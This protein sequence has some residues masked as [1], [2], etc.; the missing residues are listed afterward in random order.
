[1]LQQQLVL[2]TLGTVQMTNYSAK[3]LAL[4]MLRIWVALLAANVALSLLVPSLL[5]SYFL[6][7]RLRIVWFGSLAFDIA[8]LSYTCLTIAWLRG[9]GMLR[10]VAG[11]NVAVILSVG[12][13]MAMVVG[14]CLKMIAPESLVGGLFVGIGGSVYVWSFPFSRPK[15]SPGLSAV[16]SRIDGIDRG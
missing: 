13:L 11:F 7:G 15:L 8:L 6:Y 2:R 1:M 4:G 9:R 10:P 14:L 12:G 3:P 16:L 5:C